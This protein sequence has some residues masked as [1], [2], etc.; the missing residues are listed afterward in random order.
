M[1]RVVA[2]QKITMR[3]ASITVFMAALINQR[4]ITGMHFFAQRLIRS[5]ITGMHHFSLAECDHYKGLSREFG[6]L[7]T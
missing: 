5:L 3:A 1:K 6:E 7:R 4:L 2:C